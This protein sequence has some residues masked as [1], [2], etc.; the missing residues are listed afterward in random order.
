MKKLMMLIMVLGLAVLPAERTGFSF[1]NSAAADNTPAVTS[2]DVVLG[3]QSDDGSVCVV[4]LKITDAVRPEPV[5]A[6][7]QLGIIHQLPDMTTLVLL[8]FGGLLYH[9]RKE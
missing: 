1:D 8:G 5:A 6:S 7:A 9:R 3:I 2:P 4:Y